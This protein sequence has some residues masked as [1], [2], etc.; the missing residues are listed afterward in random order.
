MGAQGPQT[1]IWAYNGQ[2]PGPEI[3]VKR[4]QTVRIRFINE[5]DEPTSIHWHGIRIDN[6]M[7][8]VSGLTQEAVKPGEQF[9]YVFTVPDAGTYWYHAHNRSWEQVARGLYGVLI[10][11][12]DEPA[13][14]PERDLTLVIDDWRLKQDG[15]LQE[16]S[17]GAFM[18][19]AHGGRL[20]NWPTVNGGPPQHLEIATGKVHRVRLINACNSR[21]LELDPNAMGAKILAEDGQPLATP[22]AIDYAPYLLGP[23]QRVDL[24]VQPSD[25]AMLELLEVSGKPFALA[26]FQP[27]EQ[28]GSI[29]APAVI[30]A[31]DLPVPDLD[32][33]VSLELV[34]EGGAMGRMR[35]AIV[36]GVY[37]EGRALMER[38]Q[39][40]SFNGVAGLAK[41]PFF[42]IEAGRTVLLKILN[43]TSWLHAMH[44][45]GHH[46]QVLE[47]NGTADRLKPWRD[48]FL[49][50]AAGTAQIAFVADNPGKWLLHCHML[51]H[52]AAG[53]KTWFNVTT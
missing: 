53:M 51:E 36:D 25:T 38:K 43:E 28:S 46:F 40:W 14:P 42:S 8:G 20:G 7:D 3:R 10:V 18:E 5:L 50:G 34:M 45:H 29:A 52:Q 49:I 23:A 1:A 22:L 39:V 6:A 30:A 33:A 41:D 27:M 44:V 4:G 31:N 12:E 13:F 32:N 24:L 9:D 11:D 19:W 26:S 17:F 35:G 15:A 47:R 37:L 21:V 48:T 2:T 16:E